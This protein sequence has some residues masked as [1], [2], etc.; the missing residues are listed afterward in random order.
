MCYSITNN[1][2]WLMFNSADHRTIYTCIAISN[3][4]VVRYK[5][6]DS[7]DRG[8]PSR[9][10]FDRSL[11]T[12]HNKLFAMTLSD[13]ESY[14]LSTLALGYKLWHV[15]EESADGSCP[16]TELKLPTGV[17]NI[18]GKNQLRCLAALTRDD[19]YV[20]GA[21]RKN[22]Y[23][24]QVR[25]G[26]LVK[27]LDVHS[28]RVLSLLCVPKLNKVITASIDRSIKIWNLWN[29]DE[30]ECKID[31][32]DDPI[33]QIHLATNAPVG[34]TT[35]RNCVGVWNVDTGR[36]MKT[37]VSSDVSHTVTHSAITANAAYAVSAWL[38]TVLMW[39][40]AKEKVIHQETQ[41]DVQQLLLIDNDAKFLAVSKVAYNRCRC[42]CREVPSGQQIYEFEFTMK[43]YRDVVVTS[44]GLFLV[45]PMADKSGDCLGVYNI[46]T[47]AHVY[48]TTPTYPNYQNYTRVVAMPDEPQQ[49]HV[50]A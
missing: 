16:L 9:W 48:D 22:V 5:R 12:N 44:D 1:T 18:P 19:E 10:V 39:D 25:D 7:T 42:V 29:I 20:I 23:V 13:N 38:H 11:G 49:V 27:T 26:H 37:L 47:G 45:V 33:E 8:T 21:V 41:K 3:G 32:H 46:K 43:K 36:L 17:R 35:T 50:S 40:V 34:V 28:E 6:E 2:N 4:D 15:S 30:K 14:L 31:R 24:W